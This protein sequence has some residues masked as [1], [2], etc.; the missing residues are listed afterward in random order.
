MRVIGYTRV[1]TDRQA[2]DGL[3]LEIQSQAI[4]AWVETNGH[5]LVSMASDRGISGAKE[6]DDRPGLAD[7][8]GALKDKNA[9]G[10]VVYRLDR[11]ARDLV[12][13]EQLLAEVRRQGGDI[14]S[15]SSAEAG[16]LADDPDDPSR[17]LIRQILGAVSEYERG[18][19]TL[20]LKAGRRQKSERGGFAYGSPSF[21]YRSEGKTLVTDTAEAETR[22]RILA[23]RAGGATLRT[24]AGVLEGEGRMPKRSNRWH[25]ESIRRVI[26]AS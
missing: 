26:S 11:L 1:S 23:L 17:K 18:M 3:G 6:L 25:P 24:I 19:I 20:R 15:T 21:G 16:Y 2:D 8:I 22:Q 9:D 14:F 7:A 12:L 13:Q 5:E 10:V 4:Q